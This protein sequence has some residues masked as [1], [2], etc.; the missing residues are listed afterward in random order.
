MTGDGFA[1]R[2]DGITAGYRRRTVLRE[3]ALQ[4]PEGSV[5]A[6]LGRNG[7]GKT[8]LLR[9]LVGF[10][11]PGAGRAL[12]LGEDAWRSRFRLK[13][14]IGFVAERQDLWPGMRVEELLRLASRLHGRWDHGLVAR[15]AD[16]CGLPM[17]R[18]VGELSKGM[19]VL[20]AQLLA[21]GHRPELLVLDEPVAGLDPVMREE[22]AENVLAFVHETGATALYSTH[23]VDEVQP[24]ADRV[25]VLAEGG[26][27][28]EGA[29][30]EVMGRYARV[31]VMGG[32][33]EVAAA[34]GADVVAVQRRDGAAVVTACGD[35]DRVAA[36]AKEKGLAV[37]EAR[38]PTLQELFVALLGEDNL[39]RPEA[40]AARRRVMGGA[41]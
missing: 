27:V 18:R 9:V 31:T 11:R 32:P 24:L 33:E 10:L 25:A 6:L 19:Q 16:R 41:A 13:D 29:L 3:L 14:R 26:I 8:T 34:R 20:L 38:R 21:L 2:M 23:L 36:W 4:V 1:V 30:D 5:C 35:P 40:W 28:L 22:F 15:L 12:V 39:L 37:V 17:R 7:S